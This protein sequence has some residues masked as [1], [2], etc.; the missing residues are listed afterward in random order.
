MAVARLKDY[1]SGLINTEP[2][3]AVLQIIKRIHDV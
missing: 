1:H 3:A 2:P